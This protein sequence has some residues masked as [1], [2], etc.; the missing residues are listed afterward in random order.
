MAREEIGLEPRSKVIVRYAQQDFDAISSE[1]FL[2]SPFFV[3][4]VQIILRKI[5][6]KVLQRIL[7]TLE[8]DPLIWGGWKNYKKY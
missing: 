8:D 4:L 1:V 3:V 2:F 6:E 7:E 5:L